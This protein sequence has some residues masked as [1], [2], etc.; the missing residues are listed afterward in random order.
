MKVAID[1]VAHTI[2]GIVFSI[3]ALSLLVVAFSGVS[4]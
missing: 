3:A 2:L 4:A 1:E